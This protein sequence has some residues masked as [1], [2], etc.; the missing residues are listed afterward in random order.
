M[1]S[2][3]DCTFAFWNLENSKQL[4]FNENHK[5]PITSFQYVDNYNYVVTISNYE[6]NIW[7]L[8][9]LIPEFPESHDY[10]EEN[11]S[12]KESENGSYKEHGIICYIYKINALEHLG[13]NYPPTKCFCS[14]FSNDYV[15]FISNCSDVR[16]MN[17]LTGHYVGEVEGANFKGTHNFGMISDDSPSNQLRDILMRIKSTV[18]K[19]NL[20][21][22]SKKSIRGLKTMG[23]EKL[24]SS[25]KL[26]NF[27][28]IKNRKASEPS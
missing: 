11:I 27:L 24:S 10:L 21:Q 5:H 26:S 28:N 1:S 13:L 22:E 7:K 16:L 12:D 17:V 14:N 9:E 19:H 20:V 3:K 2:S 23:G 15:L 6:C 8:V 18:D 25:K 4:H